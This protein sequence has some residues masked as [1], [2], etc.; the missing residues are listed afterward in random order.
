MPFADVP[1]QEMNAANLIYSVSFQASFAFGVGFAAALMKV[2]ALTTPAPLGPF[3]LTFVVLGLAML[4]IMANHAR[5]AR[6]AGEAVTRRV[7]A[8][9]NT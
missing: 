9:V 5:L 1:A 6:D 3:R 8:G 2:G 4:A 7:Q